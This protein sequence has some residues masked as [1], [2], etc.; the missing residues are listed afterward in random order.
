MKQKWMIAILALGLCGTV[1]ADETDVATPTSDVSPMLEAVDVPTAYVLE[2]MTYSTAFRFYN[3]G[4]LMS[5]LIIGPL[6]RVNLGI[7]FDAQRVTGAGDPHMIRPSLYFKLK[8]LDGNDY[9]PAMAIGYDNQ[10]FLYQEGPNEFLHREKGAYIVGSHAFLI[11]QLDI[12][13]GVN[14]YEFD[15]D[16][17]LF[18][19]V[20]STCEI[21]DRFAFLAEYDNIRDGPTN[22]VNLGGRFTVTSSFNIDFAARNVGRGEARGGERILRLNYVGRFPH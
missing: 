15:N 9:F 1:G 4:G 17:R 19:F 16:S 2:P 20:G 18:G 12:H 3:E 11:P 10:G 5:R 21:T 14:V 6:K 22:R 13:A 8:F 7:S